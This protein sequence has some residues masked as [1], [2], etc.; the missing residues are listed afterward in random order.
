MI[1]S[2]V[3]SKTWATVVV[4]LVLTELALVLVSWIF[5]A[6]SPGSARSLLS[7]EGVRW[8]FGRL[9]TGVASPLLVW[10][11]MGGMAWGSLR[12]SGLR[13]HRPQGHRERAAW[14]SALF[15]ALLFVLVVGLLTVVPHAVLLSATGSLFPS[16]FSDSLVP[17]L[18]VG[19][20]LVSLVYG[21]VSGTT[22][23]LTAVYESLVSGLRTAAPLTL[24]C[25]LV[26]EI[27]ET[28][29]FVFL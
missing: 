13:W 18:C 17:L 22:A 28:L 2:K 25:M 14:M 9:A 1:K 21:I 12:G 4:V 11:L 24:C 20:M 6:A 5:S 29:C 16:P 19:V 10:V 23:S 26:I 27:Y 3:S 15:T 7:G 8:L